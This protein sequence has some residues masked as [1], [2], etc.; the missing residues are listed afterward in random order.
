MTIT[1][2]KEGFVSLKKFETL[3]DISRVKFYTLKEKDGS[4]HLKFFDKNR[5][6]I[7]PY[8]K[9]KISKEKSS[10]SKAKK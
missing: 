10:K 7:K 9:E 6:V 1:I 3:L 4:I 2:S 8:G 5:K